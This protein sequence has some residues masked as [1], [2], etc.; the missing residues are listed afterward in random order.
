MSN[1]KAVLSY[2]EKKYHTQPD[3]PFHHFP[4]YIALRHGKDGSWYGLIMNVPCEKLGIQ[5][6]GEVNILDIKAPPEKVRAL[7]NKKGFIPAYH[8]DKTNWISILLDDSIPDDLV[9]SLI[10]ES[11][12]LTR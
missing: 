4:D 11:F 8:M 9:S 12:E 10:D 3:N 6:T 5:G 2:A 7:Q 1:K